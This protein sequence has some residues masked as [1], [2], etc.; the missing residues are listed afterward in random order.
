MSRHSSFV[1]AV[2]SERTL[3]EIDMFHVTV[4]WIGIDMI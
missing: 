2:L 4:Y 3:A 1:F